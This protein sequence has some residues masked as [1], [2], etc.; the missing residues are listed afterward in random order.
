MTLKVSYGVHLQPAPSQVLLQTLEEAMGTEFQMR[1]SP[2]SDHSDLEALQDQ[3]LYALSREFRYLPPG[4]IERKGRVAIACLPDGCFLTVVAADPVNEGMATAMLQDFDVESV[5]RTLCFA[6]Q[7]ACERVESRRLESGVETCSDQLSLCLEESVLLRELSFQVEPCDATHS[8][9]SL[10]SGI[11]PGLQAVI[12]AESLVFV[13]RRQCGDVPCMETS[14]AFGGGE[15]LPLSF[16][17]DVI[18]AWEAEARFGPVVINPHDSR[19]QTCEGHAVRSMIRVPVQHHADRF[20]WLLAVNRLVRPESGSDVNFGTVEASMLKVA[21][22]FLAAH[23]HNASLFQ[24]KE[25]LVLGMILSL[26]RT[27]EARDAYTQGHSDR[28]ASIARLLSDEMGRTDEEGQRIH[29]SGMLHDI[30]KIGIPDATLN[31]P[32]KLNAEDFEQIKLHPTIGA[33]ILSGIPSL[34]HVLPGVQFHH[35]RVDGQGYPDGLSGD[36]IPLDARILAV[37]DGFDAM[38]SDR[39]YRRGMPFEKAVS[40]L[41]DGAGTQWDAEAVEA[42]LQLESKIRALCRTCRSADE[43]VHNCLT[44]GRR[45]QAHVPVLVDAL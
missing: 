20:G 39:P 11:L 43:S 10:A 33:R 4:R 6:V 32:G 41:S 2:E 12:A 38:T 22:V 24:Q 19:L 31:K 5:L 26:V 8:R 36:S 16:C 3:M 14:I 23:A 18:E 21:G 7:T 34:S 9:T 15:A 40:I 35:E 13:W 1:S 45:K 17:C 25:E 42:F 29:L 37:A 28:V 30:G 27:L 44:D